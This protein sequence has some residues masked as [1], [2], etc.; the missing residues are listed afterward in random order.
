[1]SWAIKSCSPCSALWAAETRRLVTPDMAETTAT[2]GRWAAVERMIAAARAMQLASP[3]EVPPNF[4]TWRAEGIF[5]E[6]FAW[7][8]GRREERVQGVFAGGKGCE[9][10]GWWLG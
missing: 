9:A 5:L 7:G 4:M 6:I 1:M 3:T 10:D 2:T 8:D